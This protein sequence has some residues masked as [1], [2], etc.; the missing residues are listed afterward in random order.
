[1]TRLTLVL[2]GARSGKS[3]YAEG[4]AKTVP[5]RK[6]YIATAEPFDSEMRERIARHR[7]QR[8]SDGWLT[9]EAPLEPAEALRIAQGFVLLDCVTVWIGNLMHHELDVAAAIKGLCAAL[10][11]RE[12]ETVVVSNE[13]G[14]SIVPENAL[15]RRFRD[16]QGRVNQQLAALADQ[17]V[18]V[19]AGLPLKLK[20]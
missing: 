3:G 12:G 9:V 8:E 16:E 14:S 20:G 18:L 11:A 4:L 10:A 15:A 6:T 17:V 13:V 19:V 2:G 1:M 5:G 7:V